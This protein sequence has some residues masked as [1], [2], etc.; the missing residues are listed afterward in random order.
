MT[1]PPFPVIKCS[2]MKLS[3]TIATVLCA[4]AT[5]LLLASQNTV[6]Q[7]QAPGGVPMPI[8]PITPPGNADYIVAQGPSVADLVASV[9]TLQTKGYA[10]QGG[11]A[12]A[13]SANGDGY[14]YQ[15]MIR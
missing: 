14:S 6:A 4:A 13:V 7:A 12:T 9:K 1:K 10:C 5:A 8:A 11:I 3:H 2:A 15:A